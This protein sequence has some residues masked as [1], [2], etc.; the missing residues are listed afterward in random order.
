MNEMKFQSFELVMISTY[1]SIANLLKDKLWGSLL[2]C[3]LVWYTWLIMRQMM[4]DIMAC[5]FYF[6]LF[7]QT[8]YRLLLDTIP[9]N[10]IEQSKRRQLTLMDIFQGEALDQDE[11]CHHQPSQHRHSSS[12]KKI[13]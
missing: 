2:Y 1:P 3:M 9:P 7:Q 11:H 5:L 8:P 6:C 13:P 4:T 12:G 10:T